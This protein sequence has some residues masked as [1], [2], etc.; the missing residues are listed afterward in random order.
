[1]KKL[2]IYPALYENREILNYHWMIHDYEIVCAITIGE[3]NF[4]MK[5]GHQEYSN[6]KLSND[7]DK[8]VVKCDSVLFLDGLEEEHIQMYCDRIHDVLVQGKEVLLTPELNDVLLKHNQR[9]DEIKILAPD[10]TLSEEELI[11]GTFNHSL[12]LIDIPIIGVMGLGNYCGKFSC[13]LEL[14][15]H[16]SDYNLLQFGSKNISS[17]FGMHQLP[18][19]IFNRKLTLKDRIVWLNNYL[20]KQCMEQQPDLLIIGIPEAIVP[21]NRKILNNFGEIA[22]ITSQAVINFDV[23]I[24]CAYF[25]DNIN[26]NYLMEYRNC[27]KY[28]FNSVVDYFNIS[29]TTFKFDDESDESR[30][31][32]MHL[33][34]LF[35]DENFPM[36]NEDTICTFSVENKINLQNALGK[37][38][39]GLISNPSVF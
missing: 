22:F 27:C 18:K 15:K 28:K 31:E 39:N 3:Y 17:L 32:Y 2:L 14:R 38:N 11:E 10:S 5:A 13:E 20:Y 34:R 29:N 35:I 23:G 26:N 9:L 1:M 4:E 8:E 16:F 7:F 21:I 19:F 30:I 12:K 25:H 24:L 33:D 6:I 36:I 37:I